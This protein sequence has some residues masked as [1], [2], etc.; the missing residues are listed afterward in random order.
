LKQPPAVL[1]CSGLL[2]SRFALSLSIISLGCYLSLTCWL[3]PVA[4]IT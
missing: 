1:I 3:T 4:T 2:P